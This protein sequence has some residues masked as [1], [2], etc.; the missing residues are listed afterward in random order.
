MG[1]ASFELE[2][3]ELQQHFATLLDDSPLVGCA[4][5]DGEETACGDSGTG[6]VRYWHQVQDRLAPGAAFGIEAEEH[7][8]ATETRSVGADVVDV[9]GKEAARSVVEEVVVTAVHH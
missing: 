5:T 2:D 8:P 1:H 3:L 4:A 6:A 9:L 7:M